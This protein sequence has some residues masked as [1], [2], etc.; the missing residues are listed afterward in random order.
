MLRDTL[1]FEIN[2]GKVRKDAISKSNSLSFKNVYY[3]AKTKESTESQME[4][5]T[6]ST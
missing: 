5:I 6:Q 3:L 2:S 1:V 4:A